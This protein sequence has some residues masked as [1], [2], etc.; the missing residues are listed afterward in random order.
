MSNDFW[1]PLATIWLFCLVWNLYWF[2]GTAHRLWV[3]GLLSLVFGPLITIY[4][5]LSPAKR[6]GD[7]D[8]PLSYFIF[9]LQSRT[10]HDS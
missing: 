6:E 10:R 9:Y 3:W 5:L 8:G 7:R 4:L 1:T 2:W